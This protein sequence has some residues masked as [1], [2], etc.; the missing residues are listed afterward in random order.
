MGHVFAGEWFPMLV[1]G[2][3]S[4]GRLGA[5]G[6][7]L[8]KLGILVT[9][10]SASAGANDQ[11]TEDPINGE[12]KCPVEGGAGGGGLV[13]TTPVGPGVSAGEGTNPYATRRETEE[14]AA[15]SGSGS[16]TEV[17]Q[18]RAFATAFGVSE[19]IEQ[20]R[21][22]GVNSDAYGGVLG[23][24]YGG[25][26]SHGGAAVYYQ[27]TDA[28]YNHA[29]GRVKIDQ[30]G[31]EVFGYA[32]PRSDSFVGGYASI[33]SDHYDTKRNISAVDSG[34]DEINKTEAAGKTDGLTLSVLG[35]GGYQ[36]RIFGGFTVGISNW[37]DYNKIYVEGYNEKGAENVDPAVR[38]ATP[39]LSYDTEDFNRLR[40]IIQ[41]DLMSLFEFQ[42]TY[43][44]PSLSL[45]Y[46][47]E[48]ISGPETIR[49]RLIGTDAE[50]KYKTNELDENYFGLA[51]ELTVSIFN[52]WVGHVGG[53]VILGHSYWQSA[54]IAV[55]VSRYF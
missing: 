4:T 10:W 9:L 43:L 21:T 7:N 15:P 41:V 40:S 46:Y 3:R 27:S 50:V 1:L 37:L 51:G 30:Y 28:K 39:N 34:T 11:C 35:G 48:W 12:F 45:S 19:K 26:K 25:E 55:G 31:I 22:L 8:V 18:F 20:R 49:A 47:H 36:R 14:A 42:A 29:A 2:E 44:Q 33:S 52:G 17:G 5:H 16:G 38:S 23:L 24:D 54:A 53:D 13:R 6:R 32:W